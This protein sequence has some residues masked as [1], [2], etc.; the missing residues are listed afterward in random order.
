MSELDKA[1]AALAA[2]LGTT[3]QHIWAVLIRQARVEIAIDAIF[4]ILSILIFS[5]WFR[6]L[7]TYL[8]R[9]ESDF[10]DGSP[11]EVFPL[12]VCGIGC[13]ILFGF[14]VACLFELPTLL[15]NPEYWALQQI[16]GAMK[17]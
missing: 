7:R 8:K 10:F 16:M 5:A 4:L 17:P 2:K 6:W 13:L 9:N 1:L 11:A 12:I 14:C 3:A 15:L